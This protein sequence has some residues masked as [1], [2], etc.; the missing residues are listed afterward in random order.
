MTFSPWE[1]AMP[2]AFG[3]GALGVLLGVWV[4]LSKS[5]VVLAIVPLLFGLIGG[6]YSLL[7]MD[8]SKP[9]TKTKLRVVSIGLG[10]LCS[11]CVIA[12]FATFLLRPFL[13]SAMRETVVSVSR[14]DA[15]VS[16]LVLR[17]R[18]QALG[19]TEDEVR[20][21]LEAKPSKG[22]DYPP[23]VTAVNGAVSAYVTAYE[24]L[25]PQD[26]A[27]LDARATED[28][29]SLYV[30]AKIFEAK[31]RALSPS[32][33][34]LSGPTA[35]LLADEVSAL[36]S[37]ARSNNTSKEAQEVYLRNENLVVAKWKL[38]LATNQIVVAENGNAASRARDLKEIDSALRV[39]A[40]VKE[41]TSSGAPRSTTIADSGISPFWN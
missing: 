16:D 20:R 4:V 26:K 11:A 39:L 31:H 23:L 6:G 27:I 19:A 7:K 17:A 21:I 3:M 5:A 40:S 41:T 22:I 14:S 28:S 29:R 1:V 10:A 38:A 24:G 33:A 35:M 25:P 2:I 15:P 30:A 36:S 34:P 18:L 12:M 32:G 9:N 37:T 8:F 13:E